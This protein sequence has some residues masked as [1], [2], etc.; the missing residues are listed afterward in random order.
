M[1]CKAFDICVTFSTS[2]NIADKDV[3]LINSLS[4]QLKFITIN[5][6]IFEKNVLIPLNTVNLAKIQ[7]DF[8]TNEFLN[9]FK[10]LSFLALNFQ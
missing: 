6:K 10:K 4:L 1:Y 7:I 3:H 5:K 8:S 9:I 2:E